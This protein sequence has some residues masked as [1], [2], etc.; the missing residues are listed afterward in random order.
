MGQLSNPT[1]GPAGWTSLGPEVGTS[2]A[3]PSPRPGR[4]TLVAMV[5]KV[6][7]DGRVVVPLELVDF[8][9]GPYLNQAPS[10]RFPVYTRGNAGEVYPEVVFPL[11]VTMF[12]KM[13][14]EA[15]REAALRSGLITSKEVDELTA[16]GGIF[17]GYMYL[18]LSLA[19][20]IAV[21]T[22][23]ASVAEIDATY[24]GSEDVAPPHVSHPS[25]RNLWATLRGV[26]YA[27]RL[28]GARSLPVLDHQ[29]AAVE[30]WRQVLPDPTT[31]TD[32]ELVAVLD[33]AV[34]HLVA[35]YAEHLAISGAAG[36]GVSLLRRSC[37]A[38]LGD[39]S[40]ALE[41]LSAIGGI[42]SAE[43]TGQYVP[44]WHGMQSN[45]LAI[46]PCTSKLWCEPEGQGSGAAADDLNGNGWLDL[47]VSSQGHYHRRQDTF[48]IF[49]GVPEGY[50]WDRVQDYKG[51]YS[52]GQIAV[53]DLNN[54][55]RLDLIVPAY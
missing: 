12:T 16:G 36:L 33:G 39:G 27:L 53:A 43:P 55:G 2:F 49:Y 14:T 9:L 15:G 10:P 34:P 8:G 37:E 45:L 24:L 22:P 17:G 5:T 23:G 50:S 28:I 11:S 19:R 35:I 3:D 44:A 38:L 40:V 25:D 7:G 51:G 54:N 48:T 46:K 20:V 47:V 26:R 4:A 32:D 42:S 6:G 52:P 31:A 21:R 13:G 30:A 29:R 41:L 1:G 18:N